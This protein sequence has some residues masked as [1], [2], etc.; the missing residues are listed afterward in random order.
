[1]AGRS[2]DFPTGMLL[3]VCVGLGAVVAFQLS[4]SSLLAPTEVTAAPPNVAALEPAPDPIEPPMPDEAGVDEIAARPLFSES[5]RPYVAPPAPVTSEPVDTGPSAPLELAGT[6]L[7]GRDQAA[8]LLITGQQPTW[9]RKG[10]K[11]DGWE[12]EVIEDHQVRLRKGDQEQ[13][14][15]MREDAEVIVKRRPRGRDRNDN[16]REATEARDSAQESEQR[17]DTSE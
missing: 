6:F 2:V 5:R 4:S 8:L 7:S 15:Q 13:V 3:A 16:D 11:I 14:V 12:L 1:M 9:L 17:E 10:Q